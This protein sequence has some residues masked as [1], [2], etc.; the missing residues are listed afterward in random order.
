MIY[1][2]GAVEQSHLQHDAATDSVSRLLSPTHETVLTDWH[3]A[4]TRSEF[5]SFLDKPSSTVPAWR[6]TK[7]IKIWLFVTLTCLSIVCEAYLKL[8]WQQI[9][10]V[11]HT[12]RS[13]VRVSGGVN[14]STAE[15]LDKLSI[16]SLSLL[17]LQSQPSTQFWTHIWIR[18]EQRRSAAF[19]QNIQ[20]YKWLKIL[21][22][23]RC[24]G[25][26]ILTAAI[27]V[28]GPFGCRQGRG[29]AK[30]WGRSC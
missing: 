20:I 6:K 27:S 23:H 30:W 26:E 21:T 24:H 13:T 22:S 8:R 3:D 15:V 9:I 7:W 5:C 28:T 11:A 4:E 25:V 29:G 2:G 18:G 19:M 10:A 14:S 17:Q 1:L 12:A 16:Q